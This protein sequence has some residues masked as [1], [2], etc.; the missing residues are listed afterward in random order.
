MS[1]NHR[2]DRERVVEVDPVG[3]LLVPGVETRIHGPQVREVA[4]E[5]SAVSRVRLES[6]VV[7]QVDTRG[8]VGAEVTIQ[9]RLPFAVIDRV[10]VRVVV[11]P[12]GHG[13]FGPLRG[14]AA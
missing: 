13:E 5:T 14:A 6:A 3:H 4:L 9:N 1:L 11:L 8:I 7:E 2:L 12:P 10:G